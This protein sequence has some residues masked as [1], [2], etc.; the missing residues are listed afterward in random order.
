MTEWTIYTTALIGIVMGAIMLGIIFAANLLG[1]V[2]LIILVI[3]ASL[4]LVVLPFAG[5]IWPSLILV[6]LVGLL[7]LRHYPLKY[8][9]LPTRP[10]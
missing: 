8:N 7:M 4:I 3:F 5:F 9:E 10:N 2:V 6:G 1:L